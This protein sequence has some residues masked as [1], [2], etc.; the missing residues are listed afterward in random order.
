MKS[1]EHYFIPL[2][3][4]PVGKSSWIKEL[5]LGFLHPRYDDNWKNI[6]SLFTEIRSYKS[7]AGLTEE[8]QRPVSVLQV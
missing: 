3:A 8:I 1:A 7:T 4:S 5:N 2:E 6:T